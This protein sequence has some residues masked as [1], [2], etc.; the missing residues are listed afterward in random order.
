MAST[1]YTGANGVV[2]FWSGS[3]NPPTTNDRPA[4]NVQNFSFTT[5]TE[6]I[7]TTDLGCTDRIGTDGLRTTTMDMTMIYN[8]T[9][10]AARMLT[11]MIR[12]RIPNAGPGIAN[13]QLFD[14]A[15]T[16]AS[17]ID[18]DQRRFNIRVGVKDILPLDGV[19]NPWPGNRDTFF[20]EGRVMVRSA[21]VQ[22]QVGSIVTAQFSLVFNGAPTVVDLGDSWI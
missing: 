13:Q 7:D 9:N 16:N 1:V 19:Q 21:S 8:S 3:Q 4:G 12:P 18:P 15:S 14:E 17:V 5:D 22:A 2:W 11:K 20:I 10:F 6:V